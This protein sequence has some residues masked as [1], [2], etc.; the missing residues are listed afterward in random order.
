MGSSS[1][2]MKSSI[3]ETLDWESYYDNMNHAEF[4]GSIKPEEYISSK[5]QK[6]PKL[7]PD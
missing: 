5:T 2:K 7:L 6:P 1:G 3:V 4:L